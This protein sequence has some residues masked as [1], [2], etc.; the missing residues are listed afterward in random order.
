MCF[1]D[2]PDTQTLVV[3]H[4]LRTGGMEALDA[5]LAWCQQEFCPDMAATAAAATGST[6]SSGGASS[7]T[8]AG[9]NVV[10]FTS[11]AAKQKVMAALPQ[12]IGGPVGQAVEALNGA[13]IQVGMGCIRDR[14]LKSGM[15]LC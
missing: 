13:D 11:T 5:L 15:L 12:E 9:E 14:T 10:W 8:A 1:Q 6:G 3:K 4:M 2:Q 7:T